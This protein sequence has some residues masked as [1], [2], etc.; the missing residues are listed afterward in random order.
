MIHILMRIEPQ[1]LGEN[2]NLQCC[3][4]LIQ[5][6]SEYIKFMKQ[7]SPNV[8][9]EIFK[10]LLQLM[11]TAV[12]YAGPSTMD[13]LVN[14]FR[15]LNSLI[16]HN[17]G[18]TFTFYNS[19]VC[20][21]ILQ[22]A[23][24][25]ENRKDLS[26]LFL[27]G[28]KRDLEIQKLREKVFDAILG[29]LNAPFLDKCRFTCETFFTVVNKLLELSPKTDWTL[30]N[31]VLT[32]VSAFLQS[33]R[34]LTYQEK[35]STDFDALLGGWLTLLALVQ[36]KTGL[37]IETIMKEKELSLAEWLL[38]GCLFPP[39]DKSQSAM[40][41]SLANRAEAFN[42]LNLLP[43]SKDVCMQEISKLFVPILSKSAW[44]RQGEW[45]I[46]VSNE[47]SRELRGLKNMG[48]TCYIN[49]LMQ[50]LFHLREFR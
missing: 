10:E 22:Y 33:A 7:P 12:Q 45:A 44:R 13:F 23:L 8:L 50:Q 3:S 2:F 32:T 9:E 4:L 27:E 36:R 46:T 14:C 17:P 19:T 47:Q 48:A 37:T 5:L 49:S 25:T 42:I 21:P 30:N 34:K 41:K 38:H 40:C 6:L 24:F 29:F 43:N 35:S 39:L 16:Q 28:L 18:I 15:L 31:R 1:A 26:Q 11:Q 20:K